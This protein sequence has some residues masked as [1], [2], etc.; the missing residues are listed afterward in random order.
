MHIQHAPEC[1]KKWDKAVLARPH[2]AGPE[3]N[4]IALDVT[5][6]RSHVAEAALPMN[7]EVL[8][9]LADSFVP[10]S[11]H[12]APNLEPPPS[13]RAR[14]EEV[15][16]EDNELGRFCR[17]YPVPA[18]NVLRTGKTAFEQERA[19]QKAG[20]SPDNC[21]APFRD[22]DEWELAEWLTKETTQKA[23]DKFLK[24]NIVS[25]SLKYDHN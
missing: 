12:P 1:R 15:D 19:G 22:N 5:T 4:P 18:A 21:W 14:V 2:L 24:L 20:E 17:Q 3:P 7:N 6:S 25:M 10:V 16:D 23:R 8:H 9:Q 13:K 11:A